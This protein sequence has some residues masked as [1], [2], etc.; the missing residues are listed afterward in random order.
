[1][2]TLTINHNGKI[3]NIDAVKAIGFAMRDKA[4][5][6]N[7]S[8]EL[9]FSRSIDGIIINVKV[10]DKTTKE[11]YESGCSSIFEVEFLGEA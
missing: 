6:K 4:W 8:C 5:S 11:M 7:K 1:M 9:K 3:A 10:D 2:T